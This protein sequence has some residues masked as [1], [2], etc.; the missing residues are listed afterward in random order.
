MVEFMMRDWICAALLA[1]AVPM[2]PAVRAAET[3][4]DLAAAGAE[5]DALGEMLSAAFE[6]GEKDDAAAQALLFQIRDRAKADEARFG[7]DPEQK[8]FFR[9]RQGV[10]LFYAATEGDP[11][12]DDAAAR[13]QEME[14]LAE[15]LP[16]LAPT[17]TANGKEGPYYEYRAATEQ[18]F[19][20]GVRYGDARLLAWSAERV[21][22]NRISLSVHP[23]YDYQAGLADA[24][25]DHGWLTK[26]PA[27][28][29]EADRIVAAI[30]EAELDWD[31]NEK[32]K[33]VAAG[34][35]P[36]EEAEAPE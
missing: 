32:L 23:D 22:A 21:A 34:Q 27:A 6:L 9:E 18:L 28:T 10:A 26:T 7:A 29:A 16:L 11:D 17:A 25:Y 5:A 13:K 15:A 19:E 33:L 24:L 36:Y 4:D 3:E 31:T 8:A 1:A 12:W 30:P 2:A 35:S 20:R 14:W